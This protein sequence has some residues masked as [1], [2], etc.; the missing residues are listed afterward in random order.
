M[1]DE[2]R[3]RRDYEANEMYG[4]KKGDESRSRRDYEANEM[5]WLATKGDESR[6]KRDYETNEASPE[7]LGFGR[8]S[9][10]KH[11]PSGIR[12]AIR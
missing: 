12:K 3:S 11:K 8:E 1:G 2:S 4:G 10:G 7:L 5:L 9:G 6:S